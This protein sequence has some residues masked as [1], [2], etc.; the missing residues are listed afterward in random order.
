MQRGEF[1]LI[2]DADDREKETDIIKGAEF[3]TPPD[4]QTMRIRGGGLIILMIP[5][6][7]A[8]TLGLPFLSDV[9]YNEGK[10]WPVLRELIP[11]DIPY[12]SK[13]SFS[14]TINHRETFTGI[15]DQ[16]RALTISQFPKIVQ[17]IHQC[18]KQEAQKIFGKTFRAPGHVPICIAAKNLLQE[19]QGHTELAVALATMAG[20]TP[21]VTACEMI[22]DINSLPKDKA[23]A[24]AKKQGYTFIEGRDILEAWDTWSG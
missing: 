19:R 8:Q 9:F 1:I 21:V 12:D 4:I 24:Y 3:V 18:K 13:S 2:Y 16:D 14:V 22:G 23:H 10:Q 5:H 11:N 17:E 7:V 20:I 6:T 15:S